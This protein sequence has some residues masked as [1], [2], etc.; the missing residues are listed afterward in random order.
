MS[1]LHWNPRKQP[2]AE[3][4]SWDYLISSNMDTLTHRSLIKWLAYYTLL[5]VWWCLE[6]FPGCDLYKL[7]DPKKNHHLDLT[8][9]IVHYWLIYLG[10]QTWLKLWI[11]DWVNWLPEYIDWPSF[12]ISGFFLPWWHGNIPRCQCWDSA[13][14]NSEKVVQG[15]GAVAYTSIHRL[16]T[17]ELRS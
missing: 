15:A 16:S 3:A 8:R 12:S 1:W 9:Q 14:S 4:K 6:D 7:P 5:C 2:F 13:G 10:W 17:T 11:E